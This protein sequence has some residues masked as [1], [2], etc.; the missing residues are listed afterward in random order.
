MLLL[1]VL[2]Y[3]PDDIG[4]FNNNP[5]SHNWIGPFGAITAYGAFMY[6]GVAGFTIPFC[7]I[8]IGISSVF[9]SAHKVYPRLL[10]FVL[11]LFCLSGLVDMN[12]QFWLSAVTRLNIGSPGGLMGEMLAQRSF[13]RWF[14]HPGAGI[15]FFVGLAI[16]IVRMLDLQF[17]E[18]CKFAWKKIKAFKVETPP[19]E[20]MFSKEDPTR[21]PARKRTQRRLKPEISE[22]I[23]EQPSIDI[24]AMV[25]Q[26]QKAE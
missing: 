22:T 2:S 4:H 7:I 26:Q 24:R 13:G 20:E 10:W 14:G 23:A 11:G 21:K 19:V 12:E 25:E 8:W 17:V 15:G 1:G 9:W 16:A 5:G 18:L 6:F 3:N